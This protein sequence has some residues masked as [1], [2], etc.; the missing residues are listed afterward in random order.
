MKFPAAASLEPREGVLLPVPGAQS[1]GCRVSCSIRAD[2]VLTWIKLQPPSRMH[3]RAAAEGA[4]KSC[5]FLNRTSAS[6][7]WRRAVPP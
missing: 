7:T 2:A 3:D 4:R 5:D 1:A 6:R